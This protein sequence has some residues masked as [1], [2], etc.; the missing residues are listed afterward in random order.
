MCTLQSSIYLRHHYNYFHEDT[1]PFQWPL[2]NYLHYLKNDLPLCFIF[3]E[4]FKA[5][6]IDDNINILHQKNLV[7]SMFFEHLM[8]NKLMKKISKNKIDFT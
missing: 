3:F 1:Q 4:I 7:L 8:S 6:Q 2:S 5:K